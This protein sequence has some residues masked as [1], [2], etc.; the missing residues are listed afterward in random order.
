[1]WPAEKSGCCGVSVLVIR[2]TQCDLNQYYCEIL[3]AQVMSLWWLP[4]TSEQ[5]QWDKAPKVSCQVNAYLAV[6]RG[7]LLQHDCN[8][9]AT[10]TATQPRNAVIYRVNLPCSMIKGFKPFRKRASLGKGKKHRLYGKKQR[11]VAVLQCVL[12]SCCSESPRN[13]ARVALSHCMLK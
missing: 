7:F 3:P 4:R 11:C 13:T 9:T 5:P 8:M 10:R 6:L 1:M 2:S 12:Q